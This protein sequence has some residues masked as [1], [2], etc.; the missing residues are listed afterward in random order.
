[1]CVGVFGQLMG[2]VAE[3]RGCWGIEITSGVYVGK[4]LLKGGVTARTY[5]RVHVSAQ[6]WRREVYTSDAPSHR[7]KNAELPQSTR[8]LND[9]HTCQG[10]LIRASLAQEGIR[11][12][13]SLERRDL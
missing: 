12:S 8:N 9:R 1:M 6:H 3:A 13:G 11:A 7:A 5:G 4:E 2:N 10:A